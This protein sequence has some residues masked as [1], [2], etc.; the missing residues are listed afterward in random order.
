VTDLD[1]RGAGQGGHGASGG[2]PDV[3][4]PAAVAARL[5]FALSAPARLVGLPR[6]EVRLVQLG[7]EQGAL[8]TYGAGLGGIAVL[9]QPAAPGDQSR[10]AGRGG[11]PGG[12]ALPK[13]SIDGTDGQELAT[14][15]GTLVRFERGGVQY[16]I[17]GSIPPAAAEA[18]ARAL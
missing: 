7:G 11:G 4:G 18:A 17:V 5:P 16:T 3:T 12:L 14:A 6:R 13:V 9:Q 1:L 2:P 10:R 15:L 8:V